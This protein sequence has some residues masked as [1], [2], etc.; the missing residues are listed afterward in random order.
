MFPG[1]GISMTLLGSHT[2][3]FILWYQSDVWH[4]V[5]HCGDSIICPSE[6]LSFHTTFPAALFACG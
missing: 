2:M 5:N 3:C 6:C 1:T 4:A